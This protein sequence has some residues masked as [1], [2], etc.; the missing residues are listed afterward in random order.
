MIHYSSHSSSD[1]RVKCQ[2]H[3]QKP[4]HSFA[5]HGWLVVIHVISLC[6]QQIME[7]HHKL[8]IPTPSVG[9]CNRQAI[10][11]MSSCS[12]L[13]W[14]ASMMAIAVTRDTLLENHPN[15][16][17]DCL[18][19]T[20]VLIFDWQAFVRW[21][22]QVD[23]ASPCCHCIV[24]WFRVSTSNPHTKFRWICLTNDANDACL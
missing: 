8:V 9:C 15:I 19:A 24:H 23:Q 6:F 20:N 3:G 7:D 12:S 10:S 11:S 1:S 22:L 16:K 13:T 21:A 2:S 4:C 18:F 17:C 5:T 14:L